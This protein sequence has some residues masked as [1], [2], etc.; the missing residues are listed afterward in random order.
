MPGSKLKLLV[1]KSR[2]MALPLTDTAG[3]ESSFWK[4]ILMSKKSKRLWSS[5]SLEG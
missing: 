5:F 3:S 2:D 1:N 4:K